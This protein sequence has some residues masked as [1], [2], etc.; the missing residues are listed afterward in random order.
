M[1]GKK[2]SFKK[3]P[4]AKQADDWVEKAVPDKVKA[5]KE[6]IPIGPIKRL[7]LDIP[8]EL[9][10]RI[11]TRAVMEGDSMVNILRRLMEKEFPG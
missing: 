1:S 4:T 8:E 9:H 2:V 5:T 10:R 3:K 11:K 6:T 7:T